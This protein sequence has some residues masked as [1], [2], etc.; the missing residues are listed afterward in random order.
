MRKWKKKEEG[1]KTGKGS[2]RGRMSGGE[3]DKSE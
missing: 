3:K 2:S 1:R